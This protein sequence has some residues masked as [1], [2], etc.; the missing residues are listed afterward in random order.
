MSER[1]MH[2]FHKFPIPE[3]IFHHLGDERLRMEGDAVC[4]GEHL[5]E[6]EFKVERR[7]DGGLGRED[8]G[9]FNQLQSSTWDKYAIDLFKYVFP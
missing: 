9:I 7:G 4:V 8:D 5:F 6:E 3:Y 1:K 2:D